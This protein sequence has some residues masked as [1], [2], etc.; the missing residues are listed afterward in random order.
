MLTLAQT[1]QEHC[2][3]VIEMLKA[4]LDAAMVSPGENSDRDCEEL[5]Y[6]FKRMRALSKLSAMM[7]EGT[8][9]RE[10]GYVMDEFLDILEHL[11]EL[12]VSG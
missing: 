5:G 10:P 6:T 12:P 9:P 4:D 1:I 11:M 7:K 8:M 2:D 3:M